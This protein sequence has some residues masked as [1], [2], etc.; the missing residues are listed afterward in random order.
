MD[1]FW[2]CWRCRWR[3][4]RCSSLVAAAIGFAGRW[5]L[6]LADLAGRCAGAAPRRRQPISPASAS[7]SAEGGVTGVQADTPRIRSSCWLEFSLVIPGFITDVVGA[8]A[9]RPAAAAGARRRLRPRRAAATRGDGGGRSRARTNGASARPQAARKPAR[10]ARAH[11]NARPCSAADRCV[12]QPPRCVVRRCGAKENCMTTTN[13][14]QPQRPQA[15]Q[16]SAAA[17]RAGAIHQGFLVRESE[18]AALAG[19]RPEAAADQHPDQRQRQAAVG[20]RLRGDAQ[21]RR[22]GGNRRHRAVQLRSGLC[23]RVPHPERA[24]GTAARRS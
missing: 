21:A 5:S 12:S 8:A 6:L 11:G 24:A 23:R 10:R 14:G 15:Q 13:G 20:H 1:A 3:K 18:C 4:S 19:H 16:D 22:Q 17:Q 7:P 2:R 9:A